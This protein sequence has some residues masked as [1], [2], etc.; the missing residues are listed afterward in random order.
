[1]SIESDSITKLR[2]V[3]RCAL[4]QG[5]APAT[6]RAL[7]DTGV[8]RR[9]APQ[10]LLVRQGEPAAH[11]ALVGRGHVRLWRPAAWG[12]ARIAGYRCRGEVAGEALLGGAATHDES[13]EAMTDVEALIVPRDAVVE[14]LARDPAF[15][16]AVR[17]LLMARHRA[18]ET[19]VCALLHASVEERLAD[20]LLGAAERWGIPDGQGVRIAVR[21]THAEIAN[22]IGSTR[23]TVTLTLGNLRRAGVIVHDRRQIVILRR[24]SLRTPLRAPCPPRR[25]SGLAVATATG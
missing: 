5:A 1:M 18:A 3:E 4:A 23:E 9:F 24:D 22:V 16:E 13:A 12:P 17:R 2:T 7:A 14:L 25:G 15:G 19:A 8:L 20:F 11:L 10:E 6:S 21:L